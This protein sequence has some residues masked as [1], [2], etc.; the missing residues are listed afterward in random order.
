MSVLIF[1]GLCALLAL[2]D[3]KHRAV[4]RIL[5]VLGTVLAAVVLERWAILGLLAG[6]VVGV[7]ADLPAGDVMVG[8]MIGAWLGVEGTLLT[9][10]LALLVGNIIWAMWEDRMID[11]PGEWPF[12]PLLLVPACVIVLT[13]GGW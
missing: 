11:W 8:G 1:L 6:V 3:W 7:V 10:I 2:F 9:W 12:T 13:K 5:P 4:P